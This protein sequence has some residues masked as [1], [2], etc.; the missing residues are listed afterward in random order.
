MRT[1]GSRAAAVWNRFTPVQRRNLTIALIAAAAAAIVIG[2]AA[3]RPHYVTI[4]SGLD[5]KSLGEV[6]QQLETLK[7]P[8][9]IQGNSVLVP[10]RD[11]DTARIQLAMAGLPKSGYIGYSTISNSFGLTED[12]FNIQVLDALQQSLD[13]T[14]E[15]IDGIESAQVHIVMPQQQLF[16]A[17][18][19]QDTAKASVFV[20]LAPGVQLT[21]AQVAGIQQLVSHSVRGLKADDVTVVDQNGVTLSQSDVLQG[22][23]GVVSGEL[24]VRQQLEQQL[25]SQLESGLDTIVGYGN[26]VVVVH[27]NVTFNQIKT[28]SRTYHPLP[29]QTTGLIASQQKVNRSSNSAAGSGAGGLAGQSQSNP[30]LST[31]AGTSG[32]GGNSTSTETDTNT[33]YDNSYTDSTTVR[34][35]IQINGYTVGVFLNSAKVKLTPA[36]LQQIRSFVA[37][38]VGRTNGS[39]G[40]AITVAMVPF[41]NQAT[42]QSPNAKAAWRTWGLAGLAVLLALGGGYA[43]VRSRRR[44]A[45]VQEVSLP[46]PRPEDELAAAVAEPSEEER[47]RD[48]LAK[49]A[50]QRPEEFA[51]LIR[52]WLVGD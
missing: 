34:D 36:A 38:A 12:Q 10:Q 33:T 35:P 49:F 44:R 39:A 20:Q 13:Q 4:M 24:A 11:A 25:K 1:W 40:S 28:Q 8:S 5:N 23:A 18:A 14:I 51:N 50:Q 16:V 45:V 46:A 15:G 2:W 19:A 37:N 29:G 47:V 22:A 7:I 30:G 26:A 43:A 52:T 17:Q 3:T 48:E 21:P 32:T 9:E 31:Y 6:Q 27:A 42:A 41:Q